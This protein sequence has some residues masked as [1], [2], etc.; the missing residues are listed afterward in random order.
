[1]SDFNT[2]PEAIED[3]KN[4]KMVIVV[5]DKRRENEG[6]LIMAAEKITA[7]D[8]NFM[9]KHG[10]GLICM[11]IIKQRLHELEITRMVENNTDVNKTAFT[12]SID[13]AESTTG[14]SAFER[15]ATIKKVLDKNS[16]PESFTKP[17]HIFPLEYCE[18]GV[19]VRAGHT[20]A[21]VDLAKL[22]GLYEAGV[23]CEIMN[24]DGSM[25]RV[26]ELIEYKK[27]HNLKLITIADLIEY[28]RHT[29]KLV[30][31]ISEAEMPTKYG[32]FKAI[33]FQNKLNGEHHIA[34][35][36]GEIDDKSPVLVRVHSECLTGDV[37]GSRRCDCGEQLDHAM[38]KIAL[39][40]R[41]ILLYMRQEGRGIGL[42]N[43]L[44]AYHLQD[45]GLDTVE[46][47]EALGFP[48][49]LRDYGIGA[50]IISHLGA[51]EL[52]VLTN[53]PKKIS[54]IYGFGLK[55]IERI[56]IVISHNEKNQYYLETKVLKMGHI[57]NN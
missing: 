14:I 30:E 18:G 19:L 3:I 40:G 47:N 2:V 33:G 52:K 31:K 8:I 12:V 20:E 28:R 38:K 25:A 35:T 49:D 50:E 37:F 11:P 13:S 15:A 10:G 51:K 56:P 7:R 22:S 16:V 57:I 23:I 1:M 5:D 54:G 45:S 39:E 24:E 42:L 53:N 26:P 44:K 36:M 4:G 48:A 55:V 41:G 9:A 27:K 32:N 17:G 21:A 29:E 6:D 34:L 46:A 43:K